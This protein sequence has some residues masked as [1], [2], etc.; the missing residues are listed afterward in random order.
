MDLVMSLVMFVVGFIVANFIVTRLHG[1]TKLAAPF[2]VGLT[3]GVLALFTYLATYYAPEG[4]SPEELVEALRSVRIRRAALVIGEASG[5][6][7]YF[8]KLRKA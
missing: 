8:F 1:R 4:V 5:L 2:S 6:A 7:K 3:I